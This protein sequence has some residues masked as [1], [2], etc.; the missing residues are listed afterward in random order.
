MWPVPIP[1]IS[2]QDFSCSIGPPIYEGAKRLLAEVVCLNDD[3][4]VFIV[5]SASLRFP[6]LRL[7]SLVLLACASLL[8]IYSSVNWRISAL[9]I[10]LGSYYCVLKAQVSSRVLLPRIYS[11]YLRLNNLL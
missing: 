6:S 11:E 4:F 8:L 7:N 10:A 1:T 3:R 9:S 2:L 5:D